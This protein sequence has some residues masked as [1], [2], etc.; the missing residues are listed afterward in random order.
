MFGLFRKK[1]KGI[2]V[3]DIV[4]KTQQAKYQALLAERRKDPTTVFVAWFDDS[5]DKLQRLF[6]EHGQEAEVLSY[7]HLHTGMIAG[8]SVVFIEHYPM[9]AKEQQVF[10]TIETGT[11]TVYSSLDEGL[12]RLVGGDHISA[13]LDKLGMDENEGLTHS[14]ISKAIRN[15][16][17]R[18]AAKLTID[19]SAN[20]MEEWMQKNTGVSANAKD[21]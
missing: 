3:R 17:E 10:A 6:T 2:V 13:M 9:P 19:Q 15:A 5:T 8:R 12:F 11:V 4:F 21:F 14:M 1:N 20:S 16:Q 18:I 7:K